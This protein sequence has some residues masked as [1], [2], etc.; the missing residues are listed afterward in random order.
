MNVQQKSSDSDIPSNC[1]KILQTLIGRRIGGATRYSWWPAEENEKECGVKGEDTFSFTAGP[2]ALEFD[3]GVMLGI[4]SDPSKNSL[5]V[6]I[7][8]DGHGEILRSEPLEA[9]ADLHPISA[10]D[11]KFASNFWRS[12]V[13]SEVSAVSILIMKP[14]SPLYEDLPNEVGLCF[15]LDSGLKVVAVHGLHDD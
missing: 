4:A 5:C 3:T 12:A 14:R 10:S 6:W 7:E 11:L 15:S 13:G 9:D 2:V 1:S 8:K